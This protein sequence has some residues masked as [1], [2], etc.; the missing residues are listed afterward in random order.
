M[1]RSVA[2]KMVVPVIPK[3]VEE[4]AMLEEDLKR[5]GC[6]KLMLRPWSIKYEKIVLELQQERGNQWQ[7]T[8]RQ[9]PEK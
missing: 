5:M 3:G 7:G 6:H 9:D 1:A 8:V 2:L 4:K